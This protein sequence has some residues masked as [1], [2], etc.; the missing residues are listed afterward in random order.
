MCSEA[1]ES[2]DNCLTVLSADEYRNSLEEKGGGGLRGEEGGGRAE[3]WRRKNLRS[4][5]MLDGPILQIRVRITE[6][7]EI[8]QISLHHG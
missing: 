8:E 3:E 7:T 2:L 5:E 6:C 4:V 1:E